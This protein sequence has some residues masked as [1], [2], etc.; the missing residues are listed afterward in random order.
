MF[1]NL[2]SK[3]IT[4]LTAPGGDRNLLVDDS[5]ISPEEPSYFSLT[6]EELTQDPDTVFTMLEKLGEGSYGFVHKATHNASGHI[7]AIKRVAVEDNDFESLV[8]EIQIMNG[9]RSKYIVQFYGSYFKDQHLW[10]VIEYCGAG[11]VSDVMRIH[12]SPLTEKQIAVICRDALNGLVYLHGLRKIHR[13]IKA[14]NILLNSQGV[15]KLADFGVTGQLSDDMVKR[16]TVIGTPFWMAPEVIEEVGYNELADVW[17]LGIT[18]IEMAD[19]FP[20][21]HKINPMRAVFLIPTKPPP[22]VSDPS[23]F[24]PAFNDFVASCLV[25]S[26]AQR[27]SA[28]SLLSHEFITQCPPRAVLNELVQSTLERISEA[29]GLNNLGGEDDSDGESYD[30]VV[31]TVVPSRGRGASRFDD[32]GDSDSDSDSDDY[33]SSTTQFNGRPAYDTMIVN[34][35]TT[36]FGTMQDH[37]TMVSMNKTGAGADDDEPYFMKITRERAAEAAALAARAEEQKKATPQQS[38]KSMQELLAAVNSGRCQ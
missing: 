37:G 23:K 9:C 12:R 36:N 18:L 13:D 22:T 15:A 24:S 2:I 26:P 25:K 28:E 27:P 17:S 31:N 11:A 6:D 35:D 30:G 7:V 8:K 14:G 32:S 10:I 3:T 4:K 5:D 19:G 16:N 21:Y 38:Q 33:D 34:S 1:K 29:G 20:P